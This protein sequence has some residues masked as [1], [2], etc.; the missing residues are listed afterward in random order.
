VFPATAVAPIAME[1]PLQ[2]AVLEIT[3]AKG[4]ALTVIFTESDFTQP[5]AFVSVR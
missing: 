3:A 4:K 5:L 2:M 1:S